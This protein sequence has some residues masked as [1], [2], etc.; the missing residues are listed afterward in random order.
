MTNLSTL[1][2]AGCPN[3]GDAELPFVTNLT[4]LK[5]LTVIDTGVSLLGTN[6]LKSMY[7]LTNFHFR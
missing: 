7:S 6:A 5:E 3:F 4:H 2:V 1:S